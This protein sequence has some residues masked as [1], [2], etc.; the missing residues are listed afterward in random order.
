MDPKLLEQLRDAEESHL[1]P[2]VRTNPNALGAILDDSFSEIGASG[3]RY[4]KSD[5]LNSLTNEPNIRR[6]I[7]HFEARQLGSDLYLTTY[8]LIAHHPGNNPPRRTH[9][10]TIWKLIN[11]APVMLHHQGTPIPDPQSQPATS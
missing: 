5:I 9:R 4:T 3:T 6:A 1:R 8:I 10:S 11:N 2:D 7:K